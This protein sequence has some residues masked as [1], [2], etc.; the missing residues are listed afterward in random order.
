MH[1]TRGYTICIC[2]FFAGCHARAFP[3]QETIASR[4]Y[5][6]YSL[7]YGSA[8][9]A[10]SQCGLSRFHQGLSSTQHMHV[11]RKNAA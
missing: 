6:S 7:L 4:A 8:K 2:L 5:T 1:F 3:F 9:S 11:T 10:L